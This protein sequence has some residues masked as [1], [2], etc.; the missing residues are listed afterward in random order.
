M[1]SFEIGAMRGI[2]KVG[3]RKRKS[4]AKLKL[5]RD[6]RGGGILVCLLEQGD[7]Q[8]NSVWME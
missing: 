5:Q 3:V 4:I 7:K 8:R 2:W 6:G 1:S